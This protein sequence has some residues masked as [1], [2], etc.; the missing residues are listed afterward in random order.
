MWLPD[1]TQTRLVHLI[2]LH[3]IRDKFKI[4]LIILLY[5]TLKQSRKPHRSGTERPYAWVLPL[6]ISEPSPQF[7]CRMMRKV[8]EM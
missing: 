5:V 6:H 3:L 1:A 7:H 2:H 8:V 4:F